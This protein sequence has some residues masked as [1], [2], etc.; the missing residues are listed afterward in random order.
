VA[1]G[2][3]WLALAVILAVIVLSPL[4]MVTPAR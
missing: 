1:A 4:W 2:L 3:L